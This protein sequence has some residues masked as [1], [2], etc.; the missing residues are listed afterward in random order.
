MFLGIVIATVTAFVVSATYY[1]V[2]LEPPVDDAGP[3]RSSASLVVVELARS[4]AVAML[5]AGLIAAADWT[6]AGAG[7]LL[8]VALWTLP[9]VLLI[10]S[11]YH[12]GAARRA[13]VVHAGDWLIKLILIGSIVGWLS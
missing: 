13:A 1:S 9:V 11:V 5:I 2:L 6:T 4:A 10:G 3:T 8:G 12:E 7:A